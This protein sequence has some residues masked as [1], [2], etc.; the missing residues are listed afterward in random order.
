MILLSATWILSIEMEKSDQKLL[1]FIFAGLV[2]QLDLTKLVRQQP[3][4]NT[5]RRILLAFS[6]WQK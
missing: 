4:K 1:L 2:F 5:I 6:F 3:Y